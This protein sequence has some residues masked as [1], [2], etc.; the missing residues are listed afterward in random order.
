M[1][2]VHLAILQLTLL[3][4]VEASTVNTNALPLAKDGCEDHCGNVSIP[5]PFGTRV[6]CYVNHSFLITCNHT[7]N[8]PLAFLVSS[9]IN[10]TDIWLSGE[11]RIYAFVANDCYNGTGGSV[12]NF[13]PWLRSGIFPISNTRN[14]FMAIGCDTYAVIYG[15]R[16]TSYTTGC[17]SLCDSTRDV[18]EGS[19]SGIGCC[20][21]AIPR[22]VMDF[23]ISVSSYYNHTRVREFNPCSYAF[24]A[25]EGTY[26]FSKQD[27]WDLKDQGNKMPMVLNWAVGDRNCSEAKKD[28]KSYACMANNIDECLNSTIC[29]QNCTNLPGTYNCSCQLPGYDGD[30]KW[31]GTGCKLIPSPERFPLINRISLGVS[32]S[33]LVLVLGISWLYWGLKRRKLIK[34]KEK[35][36]KQNGGFLLQ[37]QLSNHNGSIEATQIFTAE[38]LE[39][40]TNNYHE[41]RI[42]GQGGQGTVYKGILPD[43]KIVAIKKSKIID[44]SQVEQFINEVSIL[45]QINHRN[46]VKLLGCCLETEVP[47][48]VYEFVTNGTLFSHIHKTDHSS[49]LQWQLRLQIAVETAG[50]LSYLHSAASTPIIHRDIKSTNVLL[51]D[52][53]KAK[54]SDFGASRLIPLDHT[55]LT[56]LVQ[57]TLGYLD[58]EYFHSSLL[59]EKSDVYSFGVLLAELLTGMKAL[60]FE[61]PEEERN[62]AM[63][64]VSSMNESR[65]FEILDQRMLNEGDVE[66]LNEVAMLAKR[67]LKVKGEERPTM[68][69]VAMELEGLKAMTKHPWVKGNMSSEETEHLLQKPYDDCVGGVSGNSACYDSIRNQVG[70]SI[71][72]DGR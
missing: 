56:T 39:K 48:L 70:I 62:L 67:C 9:T 11:M 1:V 57:G 44:Q 16:G 22:G 31:D 29:V 46:V 26:S 25:E 59:T 68:K 15:S 55:Q 24:V 51:D 66:Q 17:M 33:L 61:R 71:L 45:S 8:P 36:F 6:G 43:N 23:N 18:V 30:G 4:V 53:Y 35:F 63:H 40:A 64:F 28:L 52:N 41:N 10:V 21:S 69:E 14:K 54:V 47:L 60:S 12:D 65:L 58:P 3:W 42:L 19:C 2:S 20:E 13:Q 50:A 72:D 7:Y 34:L 37:Q 49:T 5:Y 32:V 38:E 27:L